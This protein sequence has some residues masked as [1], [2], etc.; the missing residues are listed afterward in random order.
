MVLKK[1]KQLD[2]LGIEPNTSRMLSKR[3]NQLHH[4]PDHPNVHTNSRNSYIRFGLPSLKTLCVHVLGSL[5]QLLAAACIGY[6]I[7]AERP[8]PLHQ[9]K[10]RLVRC[11]CLHPNLYLLH[12]MYLF[13]IHY[14][15]SPIVLLP[16]S[17]LLK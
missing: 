8:I 5:P 1:K 14:P 6:Q 7:R 4:L 11:H 9:K 3:D 16:T 12:Y 13:V 10:S 15:C 2:K 17:H